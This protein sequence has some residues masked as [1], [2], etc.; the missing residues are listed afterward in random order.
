MAH[1][2]QRLFGNVD[3]LILHLDREGVAALA[4]F[5]GKSFKG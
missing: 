4:S 3:A 1:H 5:Q 2:E